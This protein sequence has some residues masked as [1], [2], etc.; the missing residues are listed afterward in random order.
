MRVL[1]TDA[2]AIIFPMTFRLRHG[3][4]HDVELDVLAANHLDDPELA[5]G[6]EPP[7]G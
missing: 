4:G 2:R 3:D 7:P 5:G 6:V 1:P